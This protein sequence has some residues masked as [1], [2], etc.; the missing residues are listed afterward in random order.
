MIEIFKSVLLPNS[1][2]YDRR[3]NFSNTTKR[4]QEE[5]SNLNRTRRNLTELNQII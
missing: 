5:K 1:Y 3:K 2:I 4:N